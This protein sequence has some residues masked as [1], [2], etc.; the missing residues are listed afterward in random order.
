[1]TVGQQAGDPN[2]DDDH[3]YVAR[4]TERRPCH[5]L[6]LHIMRPRGVDV[7]VGG[8]A[9]IDPRGCLWTVLSDEFIAADLRWA[10]D[11]PFRGRGR[12]VARRTQE[13]GGDAAQLELPWTVFVD[14]AADAHDPTPQ[15]DRHLQRAA[16]LSALDRAA[17]RLRRCG[18]ATPA[19]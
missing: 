2:W 19:R 7:G 18:C 1:M 17:G 13:R 14:A 6:D 11:W 10:V 12:T 9:G 15:D 8:G 16:V 5:V 3:P 4:I